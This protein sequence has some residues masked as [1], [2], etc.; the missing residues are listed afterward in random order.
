MDNCNE[1][2]P[3]IQNGKGTRSPLR[4]NR[5][6]FSHYNRIPIWRGGNLAGLAIHGDIGRDSLC[7]NTPLDLGNGEDG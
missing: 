6:N 1:K 7:L 2:P 3:S 5:I 4:N